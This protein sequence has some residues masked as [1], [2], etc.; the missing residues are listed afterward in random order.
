MKED[1]KKRTLNIKPPP[2]PPPL[3]VEDKINMLEE[4]VNNTKD[5]KIKDKLTQDLI[6]LKKQSN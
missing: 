1:T 6:R 3:S 5:Q 4:V 2:N